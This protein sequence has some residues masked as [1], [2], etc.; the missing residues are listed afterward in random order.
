MERKR[1]VADRFRRIWQ[2]VEYIAREPGRSRQQLAQHFALSARQVQ[3]DLSVI[4]TRMRLP[5]VRQQG[6]RFVAPCGGDAPS[7]TLEEAHLLLG[8]LRTAAREQ[9][10]TPE[11]LASLGAKLPIVFPPHLQ[12]LA[13]KTLV[14]LPASP[15]QQQEVFATLAEALLRGGVVRLHYPPG[16]DSTT[17]HD[18]IVKPELLLPYLESWYL[19]GRCHQRGRVMM[20]D[21]ST[22]AAVTVPAEI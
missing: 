16:D 5:L 8:L 15:D 3:A 14:A 13:R 7:L 20:F 19:V 22:V 4:R 21:L 12:P 9:L 10:A 17:V 11:A 18:P 1:L 6:Y 2:I